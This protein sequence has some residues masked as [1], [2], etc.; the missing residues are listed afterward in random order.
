MA[1][2]W[3][4]KDNLEY[5]AS[6]SIR[7][8]RA[9]CCLLLGE[10]AGQ[11]KS[12]PAFPVSVSY[13]TLEVLALQMCTAV[14]GFTGV[15]GSQTQAAMLAQQVV[16]STDPSPAAQMSLFSGSLSVSVM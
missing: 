7:F 15:L 2:V 10:Q 6:L 14:S 4:S 8:S 5:W 3:R 11:P 9:L 12:F 13:L 1:C 16:L